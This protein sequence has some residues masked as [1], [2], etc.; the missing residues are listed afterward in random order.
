MRVL[1]P[2][3]IC[4]LVM[5]AWKAAGRFLFPFMIILSFTDSVGRGD[6][7]LSSDIQFFRCHI[8]V[9]V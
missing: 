9:I 2:S 4:T 7:F 5:L 8:D 3:V 6:L 1:I